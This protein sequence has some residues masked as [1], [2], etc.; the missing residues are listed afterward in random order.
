MLYAYLCRIGKF[1]NRPDF[2]FNT[3]LLM[4][5]T[6]RLLCPLAAA[7]WTFLATALMPSLAAEDFVR[8]E[9]GS[10][11]AI[12][13]L[14]DLN[15]ATFQIARYEVTWAEWQ[16]V[17]IWGEANGYVWLSAEA[18]HRGN[19]PAGCGDDH[20]VHSVSWYDVVKWCNAKSER[21][22]LTP[23][24]ML[25]GTVFRSGQPGLREWDEAT[26]E[27]RFVQTGM[28][29]KNPA[30]NGYRLPT[31][32]E[33][34]FA[35]R[36]GNATNNYRFSGSDDLDAVG[37]Y[38]G[39]STGAPCPLWRGLADLEGNLEDRGT[40]PVG[41]KAPNEL[42]LHDMSGNVWEWCWDPC[43]ERCLDRSGE[44][45]GDRYLRGGSWY[46]TAA[47]CAISYRITLFPDFRAENFGF[48]L[49]RNAD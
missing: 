26:G 23:V 5:S 34:E 35:A 27:W 16:A 49:A 4:T 45:T 8:V 28:I 11:P 15:V 46:V 47:G 40:R 29:T 32:A 20:P 37:W 42:G 17:R 14:G 10:L 41:L 25:D 6:N 36:G 48:R 24:Y 33:W 9:G 39:N 7:A 13:G 38:W 2:F 1:S 31:E 12:S 22:G 43:T 21:D 19:A 3:P 30:A 18:D 44:S